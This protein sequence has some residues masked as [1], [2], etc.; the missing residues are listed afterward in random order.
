[1]YSLINGKKNYPQTLE[2]YGSSPKKSSSASGT[3][4]YTLWKNNLFY[5]LVI[6]FCFFVIAYT[7]YDTLKLKV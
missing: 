2:H 1:M 4:T 7:F 5:I 3:L 6:I